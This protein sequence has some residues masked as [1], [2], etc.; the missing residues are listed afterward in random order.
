VLSKLF[1]A[2]VQ[3]LQSLNEIQHTIKLGSVK[4]IDALIP[5]CLDAVSGQLLSIFTIGIDPVSVADHR[6][7]DACRAQISI[8]HA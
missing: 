8:Q 4:K 7:L 3:L 1:P 6:D 5:G 2:V